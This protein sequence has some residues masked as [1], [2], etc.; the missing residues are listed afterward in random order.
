MFVISQNMEHNNAHV[1]V[2]HKDKIL[3]FALW[4]TIVRKP[5]DDITTTAQYKIVNDYVN[6][7]GEDYKDKLFE[8]LEKGSQ[9]ADNTGYYEG[10]IPE[11][12]YRLPYHIIQDVMDIVSYDDIL[13][14]LKQVIKYKA[15]SILTDTFNPMVERDGQGTRTQTYIKD[16]YVELLALAMY[17]KIV[18]LPIFEFGYVKQKQLNSINIKYV[19]MHLIKPFPIMQLPPVVKIQAWINELIDKSLKTDGLEEKRIIDKM[20]PKD[21]IPFY[22]LSNVLV[23]RVFLSNIP[24]DTNEKHT[25]SKLYSYIKN[26]IDSQSSSSGG[27][28]HNK[29]L[30]QDKD[31]GSEDK[32]SI[33]DTYRAISNIS[34]GSIVEINWSIDSV[35]KILKQLPKGQREFIDVK[36][37]QDVVEDSQK[38]LTEEIE[39]IHLFLLSTIFKTIL[40]PRA[41]YY[42]SIENMLHLFQVGFAYLWGT[43]NRVIALM[44]MSKNTNKDTTVMKLNTVVNKDRVPE[45]LKQELV[46][47]YPYE[48]KLNETETKNLALDTIIRLSTDYY[49]HTW[50]PMV[51]KSYIDQGLINGNLADENI[52]MEMVKF[53][54]ANENLILKEK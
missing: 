14:Y 40:E 39:D 53:V 36:V 41:I 16:D 33:L 8:A 11:G 3:E 7:K 34:N 13:Y 45:E 49:T 38:F 37:I 51:P 35:E 20:L 10:L 31:G 30:L 32:E 5:K 9:E 52:R 54:V 6:Y 25:V 22:I 4:P 50:L 46:R 42:V 43:G 17:V 19:L 28:I 18:F 29:H 12:D 15:L 24:D 27:T 21:E 1:V 48:Q 26:K 23:D 47:L 44:L 2:T